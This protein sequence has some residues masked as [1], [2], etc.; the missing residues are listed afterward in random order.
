MGS[1][2]RSVIAID[3]GLWSGWALFHRGK[4]HVAGVLSEDEITR[5]P[6]MPEWSPAI[7]LIEVPV[8]YPIG[9]SKGDPNDLIKLAITVGDLRGFY[10]RHGL[11]VGFVKPRR[12]KGTVPKEIHGERV[13]GKLEADERAILPTLPKTKRHN[14]IDA[15]GLGLWWLEKEERR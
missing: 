8:I 11:R 5:A 15:I 9:K 4:L 12:W 2:V 7:A 13:V 3:P 1:D 6:P 10:R 14:M